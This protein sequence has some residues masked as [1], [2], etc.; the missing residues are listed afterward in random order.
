LNIQTDVFPGPFEY[1]TP[2]HMVHYEVTAILP[3]V[4]LDIDICRRPDDLGPWRYRRPISI[5][6][7]LNARSDHPSAK[8]VSVNR[9][10]GSSL[11]GMDEHKKT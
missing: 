11:N 4:I 8:K 3:P 1:P 9:E 5:N 10:D 2:K 6:L 7:Y